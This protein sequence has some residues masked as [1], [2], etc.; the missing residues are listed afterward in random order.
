MKCMAKCD[1]LLSPLKKSVYL[2]SRPAVK[3]IMCVSSYQG[4]LFFIQNGPDE[5][6]IP[7]NTVAVQA[8]MP[9][10][11]L[12]N[13]GTSFLSKFE[14]SQMPHAVRISS[15]FCFWSPCCPLC[16]ASWFLR[17]FSSL[18]LSLFF[19]YILSY[20]IIFCSKYPSDSQP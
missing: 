9:F 7:G 14:C 15:I 5:R 1:E 20:L 13:F 8:D 11:G 16:S 12:T 10:S 17:L 19:C 6:S 3:H 2:H 18:S 4:L